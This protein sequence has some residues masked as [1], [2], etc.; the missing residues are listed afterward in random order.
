MLELALAP[1]ALET[2][3]FQAG[4]TVRVTVSFRYKVGMDTNL[5]LLA[6]PYY[7]NLFGKNLVEQCQGQTDLFLEAN[8]SEA[9]KTAEVDMALTPSSLG[10]IENG[11]YGLVVWLRTEDSS[12][13]PWTLPGPLARTEQDNVLLVAGNSSG[14]FMDNIS[15]MMP[16]IMMVM[17]V[18][19]MAPMMQG[20]GGED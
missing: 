8:S 18:G 3:T 20:M 19:M 4:D 1:L 11:T 2:T 10:G 7:T 14:G 6:C 9:D 5:K 12:A 16:M 13:D 17:M 15:S